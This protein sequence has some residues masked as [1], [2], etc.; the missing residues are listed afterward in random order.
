MKRASVPSRRSSGTFP[1][2]GTPAGLQKGWNSE[3]VP[4]PNRR[5][6]NGGGAVSGALP[7]GN[8][9]ALPSKWEDAE[10]WIFSPVSG[11][12]VGR[13]AAL[14]PPQQRRPK[15][16]S[17][18]LGGVGLSAPGGIGCYS[19]CSPLVQGFEGGRVRGTLMGNGGSPFSAGVL[20]PDRAGY[21]VVGGGGGGGG[22]DRVEGR[23][24]SAETE[25]C[26][27]RSA[28]VHGWSDLLVPSS[29][30]SSQDEKAEGTKDAS[31]MISPPILS[32]DMATQMSPEGSS[33]SSLT[34]R[35]QIS[36]P[37]HSTDH[38]IADSQSHHSKLEV[39]D[40]QV[41][42]RVT[43]TR[44]SK[45]QISRVS[46]KGGSTN[47]MEWKKKTAE[48]RASAWEVTQTAKCVSKLKREEA[49]ITAWENLQKAKAEAAIRKLEMKLEKKRSSSMDKILNKLKCAQRKA[50][51]MRNIVSSIQSNQVARTSSFRRTR[52]MGSLS[53]CF[54]CHA[55]Y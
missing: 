27:V 18:P 29:L 35:P 10:K 15:S 9:R 48:V 8:G 49:K 19:V 30:P 5:C 39:R 43:V 52:Q 11:D 46:V 4:L 50:Q 1:S 12:N 38:P 44:W 23:S 53:G 34:E 16:K 40:V 55:F 22:V 26:M 41:D 51:E 28:S 25:P 47:I 24:S 17:G 7:F 21:R 32:K 20:I 45:K 33:Q 31:T 36:S 14:L 37:S 54:T 42:D 3:R 6:G 13:A 2:P